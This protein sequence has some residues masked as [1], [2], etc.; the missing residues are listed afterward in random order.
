MDGFYFNSLD[1]NF[2][3]TSAEKMVLKVYTILSKFMIHFKM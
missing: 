3:V 1:S 2:N